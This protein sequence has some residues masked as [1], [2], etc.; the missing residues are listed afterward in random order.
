M[1]AS[2]LKADIPDHPSQCPLCAKSRR[3][4]RKAPQQRLRLFLRENA[5]SIGK[6]CV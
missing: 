2:S 5:K 4:R 6:I 3:E 1:S